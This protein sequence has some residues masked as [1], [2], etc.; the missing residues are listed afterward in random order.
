MSHSPRSLGFHSKNIWWLNKASTHAKDCQAELVCLAVEGTVVFWCSSQLSVQWFL[1]RLVAKQNGGYWGT[2]NISIITREGRV[3][4]DTFYQSVLM[5][6]QYQGAERAINSS[7]K[8]THSDIMPSVVLSNRFDVNSG[9]CWPVVDEKD[10]FAACLPSYLQ[11][12]LGCAQGT[13]K[14]S[15]IIPK[16]WFI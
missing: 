3:F 10:M 16:W 11:Y 8:F 1:Y 15:T 2:Q 9:Q 14:K 5:N 4:H 12:L 6:V 7:S 13:W